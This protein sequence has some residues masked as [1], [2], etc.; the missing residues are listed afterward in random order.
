MLWMFPVFFFRWDLCARCCAALA[1][2]YG[3]GHLE[4]S[5]CGRLNSKDKRNPLASARPP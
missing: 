5:I 3:N 1:T 2:A 4:R